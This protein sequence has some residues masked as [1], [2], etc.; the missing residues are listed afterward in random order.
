MS[1]AMITLKE[2]LR[3][4]QY[5]TYFSKV[6]KL[7]AHYKPENKPWKLMILKPGEKA[8]RTKRFGTYSEAFAALKKMLPVIED[9]TINCPALGFMPPIKTVRLKGKT[10]KKGKPVLRT[11]VWKPQL[12][13]DMETHY[14][15]PYCRRPSI[16]KIATIAPRMRNGYVLPSPEPKMR[17]S[18]CGASDTLIDLRNPTNTQQWDINRPKI[19]E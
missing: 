2:L 15:C 5:R 10:D 19:M 8:W 11:I 6:P 16:F 9:A 3:D 14:W 7:P 1:T 17:C 12:T 13:D 18:I 4:P